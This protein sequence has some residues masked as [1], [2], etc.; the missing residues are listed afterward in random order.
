[1]TAGYTA[2]SPVNGSE[3]FPLAKTLGEALIAAS[4][5]LAIE[6]WRNGFTETL[7]I[8]GNLD[9]KEGDRFNY[10]CNG[11]Y[12]QR[13]ILGIQTTLNILGAVNGVPKVTA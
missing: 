8:G 7:Q 5:K 1:Q 13:V 9:I 11:E 6:N 4:C 3:S 2:A 10:W 12:R